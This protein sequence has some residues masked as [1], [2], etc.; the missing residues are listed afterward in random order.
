MAHP[1]TNSLRFLLVFCINFQLL[2]RRQRL[3][4]LTGPSRT[5]FLAA[6]LLQTSRY[7]DETVAISEKVFAVSKVQT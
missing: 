5:I 4:S 2:E 7:S 3:T 6:L 1:E